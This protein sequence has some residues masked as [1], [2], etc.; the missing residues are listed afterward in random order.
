M[1]SFTLFAVALPGTQDAFRSL[2][3][4]TGMLNWNNFADNSETEVGSRVSSVKAI[5]RIDLPGSSVVVPGSFSMKVLTRSASADDHVRAV[6]VAF[7]LVNK[8]IKLAGRGC[9][10][11]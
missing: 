7:T 2:P 5:Y 6:F 10:A 1:L 8:V 4:L 9:V 11:S 3:E